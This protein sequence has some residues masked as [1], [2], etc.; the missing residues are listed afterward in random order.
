[1]SIEGFIKPAIELINGYAYGNK[2]TRKDMRSALFL[3]KDFNDREM[4]NLLIQKKLVELIE[5]DTRFPDDNDIYQISKE[6]FEI[7]GKY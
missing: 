5:G 4:F 3:A 2:I 1:M 7:I 6:G